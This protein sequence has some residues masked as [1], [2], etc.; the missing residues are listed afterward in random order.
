MTQK[1]TKSIFSQLQGGWADF[2]KAIKANPPYVPEGVKKS[3]FSRHP[4]E[5][6]GPGNW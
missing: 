3:N 6:R 4:G 1:G 5:N 2:S